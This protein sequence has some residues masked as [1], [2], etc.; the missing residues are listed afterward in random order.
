[1]ILEVIATIGILNVPLVRELLE[2]YVQITAGIWDDHVEDV[3]RRIILVLAVSAFCSIFRQWGSE[4]L[5]LD[6]IANLCFATGCFILAFDYTLNKMR[7]L[8]WDYLGKSDTD[9]FLKK[10]NPYHVLGAK[11]GAFVVGLLIFIYL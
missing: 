2:D 9:L 3:V 5:I 6:F 4:L 1:M 11:V 10:Y 8:P 7:G